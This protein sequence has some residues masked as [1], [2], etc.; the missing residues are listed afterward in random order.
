MHACTHILTDNKVC[1]LRAAMGKG[2]RVGAAWRCKCPGVSMQGLFMRHLSSRLSTFWPASAHHPASQL[3]LKSS[4]KACRQSLPGTLWRTASF[5]NV[6]GGWPLSCSCS[7][8]LL[9]IG[10]TAGRLPSCGNSASPSAAA[11]SLVCM[12]L[13]K[14]KRPMS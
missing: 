14:K 4:S 3:S 9:P 10:P 13:Q 5:T 12:R 6:N 7:P 1:L 8:R 11:P 2:G